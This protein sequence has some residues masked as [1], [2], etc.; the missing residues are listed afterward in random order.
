MPPHQPNPLVYLLPVLIIL[1]ILYFRLRRAMKPQPLKLSQLWIR[2]AIY[3]VIA[4]LVVLVPQPGSQPLALQDALWFVLAALLGAVAGWQM[5]RVTAIH[6]DPEKDTLMATG[7]QAA[8]VIIVILILVRMAVRTGLQIEASAWHIN[9]AMITDASI[10]F[11]GCLFA[12]RGLEMFLRAQRVMREHE[13][14][15]S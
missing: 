4:G 15:K 13:A 8:M 5:G 7:G 1:P 10:V 2:P 11:A 6:V 9:V 3:V 14:A 12:A